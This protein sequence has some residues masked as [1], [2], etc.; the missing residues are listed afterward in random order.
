MSPEEILAKTD[1]ELREMY[2]AKMRN[3]HAE[4]NEHHEQVSEKLKGGLGDDEREKHLKRKEMIEKRKQRL[5]DDQ[6]KKS[7]Q[8]SKIFS[9]GE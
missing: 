8:V 1:E 6:D 9:F 5:I 2:L 7:Q 4:M 3:I